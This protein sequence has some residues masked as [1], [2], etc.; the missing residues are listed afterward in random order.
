MSSRSIRFNRFISTAATFWT[1]LFLL[2]IPALL[3][4]FD[5]F[6]ERLTRRAAALCSSL[7]LAVFL[8]DNMVWFATYTTRGNSGFLITRDEKDLFRWLNEAENSGFT[9][10]SQSP[11]IAYLRHHL[12]PTPFAGT[13]IRQTH[14]ISARRRAEADAYFG[15]GVFL[16]RWKGLPLLIVHTN[17][18]DSDARPAPP[19]EREVE[20]AFQNETFTVMRSSG[21]GQTARSH[22]LPGCPILRSA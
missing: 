7:A 20:R 12:H 18:R 3:R 17:H 10:L 19:E 2:G 16:D 6:R 8:S 1:S 14:R 11:R 5:Y 4:L 9:V 13:R 22:R 21:P 15:G